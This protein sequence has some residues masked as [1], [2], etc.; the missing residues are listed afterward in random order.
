MRRR[1]GLGHRVV[2]VQ[3]DF[4]GAIPSFEARLLLGLILRGKR[5]RLR[6]GRPGELLHAARS[7]RQLLRGGAAGPCGGDEHLQF[8]RPRRSGVGEKRELRPVG[9]P[10]F[11]IQPREPLHNRRRR[12]RRD[13]NNRQLRVVAVLVEIRPRNDDR[14]GLPVG[15]ELGIGHPRHPGKIIQREPPPFLRGQ[16]NADGETQQAGEQQLSHG[17][18]QGKCPEDRSTGSRV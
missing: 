17:K 12:F 13:I 11:E 2:G 18:L 4:E 5:D 3:R 14:D 9:R 1:H 8:L 16:G 15:R 6:I 10:A 7:V